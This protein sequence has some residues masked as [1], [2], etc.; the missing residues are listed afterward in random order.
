MARA[1]E[2]G[3]ALWPLL[4]QQFPSLAVRG[5]TSS[6]VRPAATSASM[7]TPSR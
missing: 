3:V 1:R 4:L 5:F 6:S 7:S 2:C